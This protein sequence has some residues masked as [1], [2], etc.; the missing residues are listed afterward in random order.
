M[1]MFLDQNHLLRSNGSA[2]T[3]LHVGGG[4]HVHGRQRERLSRSG[5][6]NFVCVC[7]CVC[8][9]VQFLHFHEATGHML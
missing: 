9:C 8:V 1:C 5:R 7:V 4:Y 3:L 2:L 6:F